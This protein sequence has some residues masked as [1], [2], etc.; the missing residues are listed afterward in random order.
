MKVSQQISTLIK[1]IFDVDTKT[2]FNV[3]APF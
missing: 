3:S 2:S 1:V